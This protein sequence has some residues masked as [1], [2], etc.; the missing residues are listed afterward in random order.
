MGVSLQCSQFGVEVPI[1]Q[2]RIPLGVLANG[3][4]GAL[5]GRGIIWGQL[6]PND[7]PPPAARRQL[8]IDDVCSVEPERLHREMLRRSV[9][10]GNATAV[11]ARR[12]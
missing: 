10:Y 5:Y 1:H 6:A 4:Y 11:R 2:Q 9:E 12:L 8:K 3:Q 7:K